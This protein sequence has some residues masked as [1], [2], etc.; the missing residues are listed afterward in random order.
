MIPT[1]KFSSSAMPAK[2][3]VIVFA[4]DKNELS[5]SG[6][7][8]DQSGGLSKAMKAA[9]YKGGFGKVLD[10]LSPRDSEHD[11]VVV[12]GLGN[13]EKLDEHHWLRLGG[14]IRATVSGMSAA[15]LFVSPRSVRRL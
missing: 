2:G 14:R 3:T 4:N 7:A 6:K 8:L 12:I 13:V 1:I 11:R 5:A 15:R 9:D 10:V